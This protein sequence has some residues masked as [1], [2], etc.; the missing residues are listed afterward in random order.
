MYEYEINGKKYTQRKMVLAQLL[1]LTAAM[2]GIILTSFRPFALLAAFG[3]KL[4]PTLAILLLPAGCV[5]PDAIKERNLQEIAADL[6]AAPVDLL[7]EIVNDFLDCNRPS[8]ILEQMGSLL[9]KIFPAIGSISSSAALPT[10]TSPAGTP[11]SGGSVLK[12]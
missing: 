9:G 4:L 8:W 10:E 1:L 11:F 7:M 5:T 3:D 6:E 2:E 12:N